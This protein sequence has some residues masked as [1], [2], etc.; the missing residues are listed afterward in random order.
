M[1]RCLLNKYPDR[2][3]SFILYYERNIISSI[4]NINIHNFKDNLNSPQS[5]LSTLT[6]NLHIYI[7]IYVNPILIVQILPIAHKILSLFNYGLKLTIN[8][9]NG[10]KTCVCYFLFFCLFQFC[11]LLQ[12]LIVSVSSVYLFLFCTSFANK[13]VIWKKFYNHKVVHFAGLIHRWLQ[14]TMAMNIIF[15]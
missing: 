15:C 4:V 2:L 6:S 9:R 14:Y 11:L 10:W 1:D 5:T 7:N 13:N 8:N 3:M 12:F